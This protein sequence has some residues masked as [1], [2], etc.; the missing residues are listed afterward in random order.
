MRRTSMWNILRIRG[1]L[2]DWGLLALWI[3]R[4]RKGDLTGALGSPQ[5][6]DVLFIQSLAE[7]FAGWKPD[8]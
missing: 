4:L 7:S 5:E 3:V 2:I 6:N 8:Q 1:N